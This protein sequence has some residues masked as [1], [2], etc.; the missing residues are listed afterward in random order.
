VYVKNAMIVKGEESMD[1]KKKVCLSC[2]QVEASYCEECYQK[3]IANNAKLQVEIEELQSRQD[4]LKDIAID[5][6]ETADALQVLLHCA[7]KDKQFETQKEQFYIVK[8]YIKQLERENLRLKYQDI[9]CLQGTIK[10]YKDRI[11]E[12]KSQNKELK[13]LEDDIKDKRIAY[14]DTP[15]SEENYLPKSEIKDFFRERLLKY[16]EADDGRYDKPY[17]TRGELELVDR[18]GEC[19]EI[20]KILLAEKVELPKECI[21]KDRIRE[22]INKL[23]DSLWQKGYEDEKSYTIKVLKK[24]LKED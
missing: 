8:N 13:V 4:N 1:D 14:I 22:K 20:A 17:L 2:S 24:I 11:Q 19:K 15:E 16:A 7:L 6:K 9:P 5:G 18:Y 10:G 23:E 12:I 3:L 21:S